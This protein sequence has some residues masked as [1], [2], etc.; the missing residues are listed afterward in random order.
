V[1]DFVGHRRLQ[2]ISIL[3]SQAAERTLEQ[4]A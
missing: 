1:P 2:R 3:R 4:A